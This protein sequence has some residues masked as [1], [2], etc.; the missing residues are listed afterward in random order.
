MTNGS[1]SVTKASISNND[2]AKI[3]Q[4]ERLKSSLTSQ[5]EVLERILCICFSQRFIQGIAHVFGVS[6]Q[7]KVVSEEL[8]IQLRGR[9]SRKHSIHIL[10]TRDVE[11]SNGEFLIKLLNEYQRCFVPVR[12]ARADRRA[13]PALE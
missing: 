8:D 10:E 12:R 9:W 4:A 5:I 6:I 11:V 7:G 1:R 2:K 13:M 3:Y